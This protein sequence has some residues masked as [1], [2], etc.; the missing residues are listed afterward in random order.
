MYKYT[1][2]AIILCSL[3]NV[4]SLKAQTAKVY[5]ELSNTTFP[6][7]H[8]IKVG[9]DIILVITQNTTDTNTIIKCNKKVTLL[10]KNN[11]LYL[12]VKTPLF[13]NKVQQVAISI[14]QL[15]KLMVE[16][17]AIVKSVDTL[18]GKHLQIEMYGYGSTTML[19]N[20]SKVTTTIKGNSTVK[21][22]GNYT[23][24]QAYRNHNG[25]L[26]MEYVQKP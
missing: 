19:L 24:N 11:L 5:T 10:W 4:S 15:E 14:F 2:L 17:N 1:L 7:I 13:S 9:A 8:N 18:Q 20:H 21:I 16:D 6:P 23:S 22:M 3:L 25:N 26:I 12:K